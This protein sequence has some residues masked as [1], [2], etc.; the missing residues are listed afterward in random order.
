M[1]GDSRSQV[2]S[3]GLGRR[4][5]SA[6]ERITLEKVTE[7]G[8]A[9]ALA[10]APLIA[11][12]RSILALQDTTL[13]EGTDA[14][15]IAAGPS[16]HRVDTARMI[17]E[18]G[19][20]GVIVA[21]DSAMSW[22]LCNGIIPHLVVTVDPH[23]YRIVRWFGDPNLTEGLLAR[24]DYFARQDMDP[25]FRN[26]QLRFNAELL[27]LI[28]AHGPNL[29]IAVASCASS[30]VVARIAESG[31]KAYWWN[32]MYDD[33]ELEDSLTSRIHELNGLPCVNAGGNVGSACWVL[34]HAVL[35]KRRVGLLGMDF[36][37][38]PETEYYQTQY[39]KEILALV[40]PDRLNEVY[41]RIRNPYVDRE[42]YTDP[43]FLWYRDSFLEM[44]Q[45]AECETYNCTDGGI[46]FGPGVRWLSLQE[47]LTGWPV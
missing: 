35:R 40:G 36:G 46:L 33:Y 20:Q 23:P 28:N 24:D 18:S 7:V 22:C 45:G 38:Y 15:V 47:F 26:D 11:S 19:F 21:T 41:M 43:I 27:E 13:M 17:K 25:R 29:R 6:L 5:A 3:A 44:A 32:P 39:Y 16:L 37:Y 31:M 10:N 14:L 9:N 34:A 42:F 12:G 1:V 4:I 8:F 30:P 2:E